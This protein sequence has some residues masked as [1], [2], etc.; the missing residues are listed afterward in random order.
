MV[1]RMTDHEKE[2]L[3]NKQAQ[4]RKTTELPTLDPEEISQWATTEM[5]KMARVLSYSFIDVED[6]MNL[7]GINAV[8]MLH[9]DSGTLVQT[10]P[11][12]AHNQN[13]ERDPFASIR[14]LASMPDFRDLSVSYNNTLFIAGSI[15]K[16]PNFFYI[17]S[18]E[19]SLANYAL[20]K[21]QLARVF[22]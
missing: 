13:V 20:A 10:M 11:K 16:Q 19:T 21:T 7:Q 14:R 8:Y 1:S 22:S 5:S 9:T 12:S 6:L 18:L 3:G 2:S 4:E 15:P 17:V